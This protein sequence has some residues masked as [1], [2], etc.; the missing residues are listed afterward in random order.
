MTTRRGNAQ[1]ELE[2]GDELQPG[3]VSLPNGHGLDYR[4]S[5]GTL[6][7]KGVS[8]NQLNDTASRDAFAGTPWHKYVLIR[9][10][11]LGATQEFSP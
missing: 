9:I 7:D 1:A 6:V 8:L 3:H 5:D 2:L 11:R 10:E 4:A